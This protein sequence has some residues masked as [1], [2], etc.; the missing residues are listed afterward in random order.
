MRIVSILV[1]QSILL[2]PLTAQ[3]QWNNPARKSLKSIV[4]KKIGKASDIELIPFFGDHNGDEVEDALIFSYHS[5]KA[6]G[7]STSLDVFLFDGKP[8]GFTFK[9]HVADIYGSSPRAAVFSNGSI[10][11]TLTTLGP[12][13][14]RCC[15]TSQKTYTIPTR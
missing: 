5:D 6:G 3:A 12:D 15:P 8:G 13:D 4:Y 2:F 9:R 14:P 11:V 1:A 7:N 10:K